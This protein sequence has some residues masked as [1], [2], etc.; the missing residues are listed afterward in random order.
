MRYSPRRSQLRAFSH[1]LSKYNSMDVHLPAY[2]LLVI[3]FLKYP[4]LFFLIIFHYTFLLLVF[5]FYINILI[6]QLN[7]I[8]IIQ[9]FIT[10][11][12]FLIWCFT[13]SDSKF[14]PPKTQLFS[15]LSFLISS[16][17]LLDNSSLFTHKIYVSKF[18]IVRRSIKANIFLF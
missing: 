14:T 10:R 9:V 13:S 5:Y 2:L 1:S 16:L 18:M 17:V 4:T 8:S 3:P 12:I 7:Y 6:L 11:I 15:A